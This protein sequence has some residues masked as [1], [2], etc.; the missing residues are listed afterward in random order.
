MNKERRYGIRKANER[1]V[2]VSLAESRND[3][4]EAYALLLETHRRARFPLEPRR[5][6]EEAFRIFHP[7]RL[8]IFVARAERQP[9]ATSVIALEGDSA[10]N[11]YAG[12]VDNIATR[13]LYPNDAT[14]WEAIRWS[15]AHGFSTFDMG[16]GGPP[17]QTGGFV[18]FKREFGGDEVDVGHYTFVPQQ[19]KFGVATRGFDL[20][21][22]IRW[23]GR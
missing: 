10:V 18:R 15:K 11:W 19:W 17:G 20:I 9:L 16:G 8:Q 13:R 22:R 7:D 3:V 23:M 1:G 4:F 6:F 12:S 5:F 21:R 2:T 14:L